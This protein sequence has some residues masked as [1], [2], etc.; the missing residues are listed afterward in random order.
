MSLL[1]YH[2]FSLAVFTA[3]LM[4]I[5]LSNWCTLRR[6]SSYGDPARSPRVSVLIPARNE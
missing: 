4:I 3:V 2:Y 6:L 1:T 5:A